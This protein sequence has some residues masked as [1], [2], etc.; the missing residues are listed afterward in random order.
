MSINLRTV[1][2]DIYYQKH[3]YKSLFVIAARL[4]DRTLEGTR[5]PAPVKTDPGAHP[6][7]NTTGKGSFP[8]VKRPRRG[9]DHPPASSK[10]VTETVE[11]YTTP[12]L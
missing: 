2:H 6:R 4:G 10:E 8:L 12:S 5:F 9:V 7:S 1:V 11:L 3:S